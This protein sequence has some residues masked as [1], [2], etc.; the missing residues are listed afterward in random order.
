ML[1][2]AQG[3]GVLKFGLG[4]SSSGEHPRLSANVLKPMEPKEDTNPPGSA[5]RQEHGPVKTP[6]SEI[7]ALCSAPAAANSTVSPVP[8]LNQEDKTFLLRLAR[9]TIR[10]AAGAGPQPRVDEAVLSPPLVARHG[11]F[12]TLFDR[13]Q[14]RG[15]I[16]HIFA[17]EPL[18]RTVIDSAH[19]AAMR[20]PR[21]PAVTAAEVDRL[22]IEISIL[23]EPKLIE[24]D[25]P[26]S[27]LAHIQPGRHG[28]VLRLAS[29]C[30][31][32]LPQ[33]WEHFPSVEEFMARLC[34]KAGV[35]PQTWRDP[36]VDLLTYEV[37]TFEEEAPAPGNRDTG[38]P[39]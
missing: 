18:W 19:G 23:S 7:R 30:W 31:T 15:C 22:A 10:H 20:D 16:G 2:K 17:T 9:E 36:R 1:A 28:V 14:L 21:F 12:V 25:T 26:E 27:R 29:R 8:H 34:A 5:E 35:D 32:F 13:E 33:V 11:C 39:T 6:A 4:A 37:E 3:L 24:A 38:E